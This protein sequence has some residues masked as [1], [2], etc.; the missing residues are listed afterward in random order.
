VVGEAVWGFCGGL[1]TVPRDTG[2]DHG[3]SR[4]GLD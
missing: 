4:M 3:G 1:G 2:H